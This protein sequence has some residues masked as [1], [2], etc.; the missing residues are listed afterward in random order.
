[1]L[2]LPFLLFYIALVLILPTHGTTG[3]ENR[4]L[5]FGQNLIH[6]F[7]SPPY[8]DI[9]DGPGYPILLMPFLALGLPLICVTLL[10]AVLYYMSVILLFKALQ[11]VVSFPTAL[12]CSLFWACFYNSYEQYSF[13]IA[14]NIYCFFNFIISFSFY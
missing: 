12:I 5:M 9:G 7:Y 6:G 10:N 4:Y 1:M 13:N 2:F 3:D 8:I 11:Q 14:G